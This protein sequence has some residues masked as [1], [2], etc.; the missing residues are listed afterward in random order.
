MRRIKLSVTMIFVFLLLSRV[1]YGEESRPQILEQLKSKL[2]EHRDTCRQ[3]FMPWQVTTIQGTAASDILDDDALDIAIDIASFVESIQLEHRLFYEGEIR[4]FIRERDYGEYVQTVNLI[5]SE[6][7]I[8]QVRLRLRKPERTEGREKLDE[9]GRSNV[10]LEGLGC[11]LFGSAVGAWIG[12]ET[13]QNMAASMAVGAGVGVAFCTPLAH[14]S[15]EDGRSAY[16]YDHT[17][18]EG[19]DYPVV[20]VRRAPCGSVE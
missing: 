17:I 11:S 1:G 16:Y 4:D 15:Q 7:V 20:Y 13:N 14:Y 19:Y 9:E 18:E 5:V 10:F 2:N 3:E 6:N 8:R 12:E